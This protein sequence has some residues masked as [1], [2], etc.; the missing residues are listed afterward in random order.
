MGWS[1]PG[2][3]QVWWSA[4]DR[5][6]N[7]GSMQYMKT[8]SNPRDKNELLLRLKNVRADSQPRW[9]AMSAHQMICHLSDSFRGSLGEKHVSLA[10]SLLK[11]TL[12]KWVALWVPLPWPHGIKTLPEMDQ[13]QGGTPP[14]EFASDSEKFR[15][16]F[17]RF[18]SS[19]NELAPHGMFGQMSRSER[20]RH[21]YL[22]IDHHLR[23]FGA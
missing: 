13:Q 6:Y 20:M 23:Q 3:R 9:G 21:A 16:L 8:L 12:V 11:R 17:E 10:T 22:H 18:C 5:R 7:A 4:G 1:A 14:S 19:E 2:P 15:I